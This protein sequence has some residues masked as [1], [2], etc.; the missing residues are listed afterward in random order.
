MDKQISNLDR[1]FPTFSACIWLCI[2]HTF[3]SL[4]LL[5]PYSLVVRV[6]DSGDDDGGD[7]AVCGNECYGCGGGVVVAM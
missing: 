7:V 6:L 5:M 2:S 4:L 1:Y 3:T